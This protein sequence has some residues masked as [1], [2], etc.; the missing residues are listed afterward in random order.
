MTAVQVPCPRCLGQGW[1][2]PPDRSWVLCAGCDGVGKAWAPGGPSFGC[3]IKLGE[4]IA[5]E[6]VTLGNGDVGRIAWHSP[7]GKDKKNPPTT[8]F[9]TLIEFGDEDDRPVGY[10][11][12]T[13]V[14]SVAI[15]RGRGDDDHFG[16]RGTDAGDP[17]QRNRNTVGMI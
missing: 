8:T 12:C 13:G 1:L 6:I 2:M 11:S 10:P 17:M 7:R 9:L 15:Q 14:A 3:K 5:G 16:D 4:R